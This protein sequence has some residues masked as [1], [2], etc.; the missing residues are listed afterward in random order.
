[1]KKQAFEQQI[2]KYEEILEQQN[3]TFKAI[4]FIKLLHVLFLVW[5]IYLIVTGS[6]ST[7]VLVI[8]GALGLLL[9]GFW[10][11]HEKL[12]QQVNYSKGIIKINQRHL[13]RISGAWSGFADIGSEFVNHDHPYASDLDIV[14]KKSVFQ[15]LNT[16]N[17]WHGRQKFANDL[18]YPAY[19]DTEIKARQAAITELAED[20]VFSN[21]IAVKFSQIGVHAGAKVIAKRLEN[22]K[23]FLKNDGLK[24]LLVYGPLVVIF[25]AGFAFLTRFTQLYLPVAIFFLLQLS[26]WLLSFL[27]TAK[28]LE[29]VAYLSYNLNEYSEVI[30]ELEQRKFKS[31]RLVDIQKS[32]A[33]SEASASAAIKELARISS[34]ANLRRNVI[35]WVV[36]N[37]TSLWD[38]VTAIRF[39]LWKRKYAHLAE[40]WFISLGDFESLLSFSHLPN[41]VEGTCVPTIAPDKRVTATALGHPLILNEKRVCNDV[42]CEGNIFIISGS[43]MSG[44]TTFMRTVGVNVVLA[45]AGSFVCAEAMAFAQLAVMTSMRIADDLSE[46]ISMFYAELTRI[47]GI[48]EMARAEPEMLFLIDEVFRGTNSVDR[49]VGARTIL[50]KLDELGVVG[51]ITTHDL[52]LCE[53]ADDFVRMKNYSF[54]ERYTDDEI[55]FDYEMKKGVSTTTNAKYLMK[56]MGII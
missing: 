51:M 42:A 11:Y 13:D 23:P 8:S 26:I 21:H 55:H 50:K 25:L 43:N 29:D 45:R 5:V 36:L 48:I 40:G 33:T 24:R 34:R 10:I 54:S 20:I 27:P 46:G 14:G 44:K 35:A 49:L 32:L 41:V 52:E 3:R 38:L 6:A 37:L 18:L 53:I 9:V 31:E 39:D 22:T 12:K 4:G 28:Y 15:F 19:S 16:T 17:T 7:A 56:M 2:K 1:M 47:K 30:R